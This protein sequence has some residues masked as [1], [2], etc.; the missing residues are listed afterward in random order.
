M[1]NNSNYRLSKDVLV[2]NCNI[3]NYTTVGDDSVVVNTTLGNYVEI[4]R[5]N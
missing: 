3:G 4:D 5:R 2:N 1:G